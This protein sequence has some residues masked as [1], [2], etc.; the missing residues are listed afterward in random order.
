MSL[1]SECIL[2]TDILPGHGNPSDSYIEG[3]PGIT[4]F[5]I[6]ATIRVT[7][8]HKTKHKNIH[9][10]K[11]HL[12][13]ATTIEWRPTDLIPSFKSV[14]GFADDTHLEQ[15]VDLLEAVEDGEP[16]RRGHGAQAT[17]KSKVPP[18]APGES[19]D[20]LYEYRVASPAQ[21]GPTYL[22]HSMTKPW[23]GDIDVAN[24]RTHYAI[25]VRTYMP[26][27]NIFI[28]GQNLDPKPG[29]VNG[30]PVNLP[31][32][33]A[34]PST[35]PIGFH[36]TFTNGITF[37]IDGSIDFVSRIRVKEGH[38]DVKI[39]ELSIKIVQ[40][41]HLLG[42]G[43]TK[44]PAYNKNIL[45][46][47]H[48]C[49]NLELYQPQH[50]SAP[51]KQFKMDKTDAILPTRFDPKVDRHFL[52]NHVLH[53]VVGLSGAKDCHLEREEM[54]KF[55]AENAVVVRE[56]VEG[57]VPPYVPSVPRYEDSPGRECDESQWYERHSG[58][59]LQRV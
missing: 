20:F 4:P 59:P 16:V 50:L 2:K 15:R 37:D 17:G 24:A 3:F 22:P 39:K 13:G 52:V 9:S 23:Y 42:I 34:L 25:N 53:V 7:N 18:L 51:L 49:S 27:S 54:V 31:N 40:S 30:L 12:C 56:V 48:P 14:G 21:G 58:L 1:Y 32:G 57:L 28:N 43:Q 46:W 35:S 11:V 19:R 41:I 47:D 10:I 6:R 26:R 36:L 33:S 45:K 8:N 5:T 55:V 44:G 38:P 29:W